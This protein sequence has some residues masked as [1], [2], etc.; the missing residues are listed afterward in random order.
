MVTD[1]NTAMSGTHQAFEIEP[2]VHGVSVTTSTRIATPNPHP[3]I[4]VESSEAFLEHDGEHRITK[5]DSCLHKARITSSMPDSCLNRAGTSV[6]P[7]GMPS[8]QETNAAG[9]SPSSLPVELKLTQPVDFLGDV[10]PKCAEESNRYDDFFVKY[11]SCKKLTYQQYES[12][13]DSAR[14]SEIF[15]IRRES[16]TNQIGAWNL[17]FRRTIGA[18]QM[19]REY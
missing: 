15:P 3:N 17:L 10:L 6:G 16:N 13:V 19:H 11:D 1:S 12:W 9:V 18:K 14:R 4:L 5:Y 2:L 7:F 8:F